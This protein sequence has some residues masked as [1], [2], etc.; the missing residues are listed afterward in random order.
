M[1]IL[2]TNDDGIKAKGIA[3][4]IEV[5]KHFGDVLVVAPNK[6]RSGM[7]SAITVEEPIRLTKHESSKGFESYSCTGTPVDCVKLAFDKLLDSKPDLILS[8]INHGSN[9]S[10]S[11]HYSG[12]MGAVIEGCIHQVPSIGFSL[13]D[14]HPNADFSPML[15]FIKQIIEHTLSKGLP[16]GT[17]LN[18]NAPKGIP[19]GIEVCRQ[20]HGRWI[21]EFDKRTDPHNRDYYWITG[22]YKNMDNGSNDTDN[23]VLETQKISVVPIV[24]DLTNHAFLEELKNWTF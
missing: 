13:C 21:E 10:V 5:A 16:Q 23:H 1:K 14:Y 4:L 7:S 3:S 6:A 17:C 11:V 8:G 2:I 22:Y 20:G 19:T 15:P 12:T 9:S 24:V 18:V